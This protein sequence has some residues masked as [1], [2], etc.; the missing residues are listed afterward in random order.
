[1]NEPVLIVANDFATAWAKALVKLKDLSWEG[2][3]FVVTINDPL[4]VDASAIKYLDDFTNS[5]NLISPSK[6]QHTIF[7]QR[8]Y[9]KCINNRVELYRRYD[10]FYSI[11]R[12]MPH[13]AWGTYF[14]RMISYETIKGKEYDQL[15]NIIDHINNRKCTYGSSNIMFIPQIESE[16]NKT[17]GAPCLNY[18]TVQV[19]NDKGK[20]T[21]SLLAVY[22][23][24]DFRE[25]TFGNYWG[26]CS[27]LKY[28]CTETN[29]SVGSLTC[30]SS[31]AFINNNKT[32]LYEISK[33]IL[34]E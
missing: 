3:N 32:Q 22:R 14:K 11:T 17:M 30:I 10:R 27:L 16:S 15:G 26:L 12:K 24:H 9:D 34:G 20:R 21:I 7:P 33:K 6:V 13:H 8:I 18:I 28:I 4:I 31:H 2:W 1:M 23:N 19:E 29:S 5:K 25:R